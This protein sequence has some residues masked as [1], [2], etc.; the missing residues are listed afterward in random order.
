MI[1]ESDDGNVFGDADTALS[2]GAKGAEG[3]RAVVTY[4]GVG[5]P[6]VRVQ[7]LQ[8]LQDIPVTFLVRIADTVNIFTADGDSKFFR[9]L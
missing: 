3:N 6:C 4:K 8:I 1:V 7:G 5:H 2:E 9:T